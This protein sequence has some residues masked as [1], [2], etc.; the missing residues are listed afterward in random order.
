M[1]GEPAMKSTKLS[2]GRYRVSL[3]NH[4]F[5]LEKLYGDRNWRLY[6]SLETE[7]CAAETKSGLLQVM[8][9]W[10]AS[11]AAEYASQEF[12]TYA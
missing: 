9:D 10:S 2:P 5:T 7:V 3:H 8:R 12:C 6:N 1:K 11:K 4:A